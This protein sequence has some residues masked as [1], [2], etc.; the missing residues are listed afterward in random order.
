MN[1]EVLRIIGKRRQLFTAINAK[2][3]LVSNPRTPP[4]V[5]LEYIAD[6]T[7][8][9]TEELLRRSGIHPEIRTRLRQ[10]YNQWKR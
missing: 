5:S 7:K 4:A 8:R 2:I 3:A 10:R 9:D 6:L 1:Q